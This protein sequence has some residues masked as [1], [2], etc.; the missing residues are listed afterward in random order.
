MI[1]NDILLYLSPTI[2][3]IVNLF[4][5]SNEELR[6]KMVQKFPYIRNLWSNAG[7]K[8]K[9]LSIIFVIDFI[10]Y[11]GTLYI[12]FILVILTNDKPTDKQTFNYL[13]VPC[14]SIFLQWFV[15]TFVCKCVITRISSIQEQNTHGNLLSSFIFV[16]M[17]TRPEQQPELV[18]CSICFESFDKGLQPE[19]SCDCSHKVICENCL[20]QHL[21]NNVLCP[22]CRCQI[23]TIRQIK[24]Q[25]NHL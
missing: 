4:L 5:L 15:F 8:G 23:T 14:L 17:I 20:L 19:Y 25:Q 9:E 11:F 1:V 22:W 18:E 7:M 12:Q 24:Y 2:V 21:Q 10:F 16:E 6:N 3:Q 13:F